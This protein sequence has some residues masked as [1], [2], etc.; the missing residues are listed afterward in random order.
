MSSQLLLDTSTPII[1]TNK[2]TLE[3]KINKKLL[4]SN[5]S[6]SKT[7]TLIP[8][9]ETEIILTNLTS[10]YIVYRTRITRKKYYAVEPSHIV[11]SPNSNIKVKITFYFNQKEKFPPEGHKFRFEGVV[12][13]NNMKNRDSK[14]IFE[15]F[16]SNKKQVKGNSIKKVVEFIFDDNYNYIPSSDDK[17]NIRLDSS[18]TSIS[19]DFNPNASVY[20]NALGKSMERPSKLSLRSK[21]TSG[22]LRGK[23]QGGS[24]TFDPVKLKQECDRLQIDYD[25]NLKELNDIKQKISNLTAK[26]KFRYIVPDV[27]FSSVSCKMIAILF[28]TAFFLGFYLTK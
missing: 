22:K 8:I 10:N 19:S 28:G 24:E 21:K 16:I 26:N 25:N 2:P 23:K 15:E 14:E 20:S 6:T 27:N 13:P 17:N 7:N 11:I 12:I 4:S 18:Q 3:F 9:S 1:F 5:L